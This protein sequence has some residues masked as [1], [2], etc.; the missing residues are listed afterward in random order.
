[1]DLIPATILAC[2]VLHNICLNNIDE[3]IDDYIVE[4]YRINEQNVERDEE[5]AEDDQIENCNAEGVARRNYIA[6]LLYRERGR[7]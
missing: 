5:N 1:M 7:E 3:E 6:L 4:G 2:C